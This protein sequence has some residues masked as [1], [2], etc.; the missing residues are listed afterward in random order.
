[1]KVLYHQNANISK[2]GSTAVFKYNVT[3]L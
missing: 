2:A 1:M 3:Q